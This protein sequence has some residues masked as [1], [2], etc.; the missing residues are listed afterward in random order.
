MSPEQEYFV[1]TTCR[2]GLRGRSWTWE[3]RRRPRPLGVLLCGADF[4]TESAAKLAGEKA[5]AELLRRLAEEE[6]HV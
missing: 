1:V 3:V 2:G 4:R 6:A 5:L